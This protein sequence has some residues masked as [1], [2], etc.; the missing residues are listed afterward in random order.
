MKHYLFLSVAIL[1]SIFMSSCGVDD[2]VGVDDVQKS[3]LTSPLFL[4]YD[5]TLDQTEKKI[6]AFN[7]TEAVKGTITVVG[8]NILRV[9]S[10]WFFNSWN[11]SGLR[12]TLTGTDINKNYDL[13][14][15]K[16]LTYYAIAFGTSYVCIPSSNKGLDG[17]RYEE[18]WNSRGLT[19]TK[20][21]E[22]LRK[23][24][25]ENTSVDIKLNN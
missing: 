17:V 23:S 3:D 20:F 15:V 6:W 12:L 8:D 9:K 22:A 18:V 7:E 24:N 4:A 14:Q 1:C 13:K 16:V 11:L 5:N 19:N 2:V 21:W 10:D 25:A